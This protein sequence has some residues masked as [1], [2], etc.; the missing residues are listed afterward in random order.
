MRTR[1]TYNLHYR[2]ANR[3][4]REEGKPSE[5]E[6]GRGRSVGRHGGKKGRHGNGASTSEY[7]ATPLRAGLRG[8]REGFNFIFVKGVRSETAKRKTR[9]SYQ[10]EAQEP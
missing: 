7:N 9:I 4:H 1:S 5:V 3:K 2:G 8:K 6:R 10:K